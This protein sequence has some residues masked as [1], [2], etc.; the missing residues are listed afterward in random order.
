VLV[1]GFTKTTL[2]GSQRTWRRDKRFAELVNLRR[3][4][5]VNS[6]PPVHRIISKTVSFVLKRGK[7][8]VRR[9]L[10]LWRANPKHHQTGGVGAVTS[11]S[12]AD[13]SK[14]DTVE[15]RPVWGDRGRPTLWLQTKVTAIRSTIRSAVSRHHKD[16]QATELGTASS[17]SRRVAWLTTAGALGPVRGRRPPRFRTLVVSRITRTGFQRGRLFSCPARVD[18][19]QLATRHQRHEVSVAWVR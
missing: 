17:V 19:V 15:L 4:M 7:Y 1:L 13:L 10:F 14:F 6:T 3:Y 5:L 8:L 18:G 16:P 12:S 2:F 9:L 11:L